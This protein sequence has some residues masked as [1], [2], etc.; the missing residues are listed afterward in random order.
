MQLPNKQGELKR[1]HATKPPEQIAA[2]DC[3][4]KTVS[5]LYG[6]PA[7]EVPPR[8]VPLL[9]RPVPAAAVLSVGV[10]VS[11]FD[12]SRGPVD[13]AHHLRESF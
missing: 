10:V 13:V 9:P 2:P 11:S 6:S 3:K 4:T 1:K 5:S 7:V 12:A 8:L